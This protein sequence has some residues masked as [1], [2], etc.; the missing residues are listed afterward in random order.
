M[1]HDIAHCNGEGCK[2]RDKCRRYL[3]H[4]E[5]VRLKLDY[6]TYLNIESDVDDCKM[7]WEE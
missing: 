2:R 1:T 6:L 7:F 4:L 3:A 5:A